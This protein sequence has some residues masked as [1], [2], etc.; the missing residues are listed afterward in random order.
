MTRS[1]L[2]ILFAAAALFTAPV[3][4]HPGVNSA[5]NAYARNLGRGEIVGQVV[6]R[7]G[8]L[9]RRLQVLVNGREW[10]LHVDNNVPVTH[11]RQERSVHDI[12][13]GTYIR[14]IGTRIGNT[15][16]KANR[17]YIVGDRLAMARAG[18][19]RRGYYA[20]Y[21]GYRSRYRAR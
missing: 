2:S 9:D 17:V 6:H 11:G 18:Y 7:T 3:A 1:T 15:R 20:T 5:A 13:D 14:A 16:L 21:A 4:F 12:H 8:P 19:P 10:T